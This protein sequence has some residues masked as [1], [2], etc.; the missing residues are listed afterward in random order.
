MLSAI[1]EDFFPE[2]LLLLLRIMIVGKKTTSITFGFSCS[3]SDVKGGAAVYK[4]QKDYST[5][6]QQSWYV[7]DID[8]NVCT[9]DRACTFLGMGLTPIKIPDLPS[10]CHTLKS[11]FLLQR[12]LLLGISTLYNPNHPLFYHFLFTRPLVNLND[13]DPAFN[14]GVIWKSSYS[15][16]A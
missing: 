13:E 3:Y 10:A 6:G 5:P 14:L 12:L 8:H 16:V 9:I 15:L 2:T 7:A 4:E 11:P 1:A